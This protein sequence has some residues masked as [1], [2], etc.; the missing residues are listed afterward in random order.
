[1]KPRIAVICAP[2]PGN[3]GM[4]S[5]DL[6]AVDFLSRNGFR[7]DLFTSHTPPRRGR[8][9][10]LPY[11]V[12][13]GHKS[14]SGFGVLKLNRFSN[15]RQF[16]KYTDVLYWGD[17]TPNPMY[18]FED[19]QRLEKRHKIKATKEQSLEKWSRLYNLSG[20]KISSN[21]VAVG[22]NFQHD[23]TDPNH[24]YKKYLR[25]LESNFD[26]I[27]PR[28]T[29][30][31]EN[32]KAHFSVEGKSKILPG[33]DPAFLLKDKSLSHENSKSQTFCYRF[34]R[35]K[36]PE[37]HGFINDIERLTGC[38][39]VHLDSWDKLDKSTA[40]SVFYN[41]IINIQRSRF[42]VTDLYHLAIN[43]IRLNVPAFGIGNCVE[44]QVGSLGDFK[45]KVLF[46][47]LGLERYYIE[48]EK[49]NGY[50]LRKATTSIVDELRNY[51][52]NVSTIYNLKDRLVRE[53]DERLLSSLTRI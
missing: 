39:G 8:Q 30:S 4:Y 37:I 25:N 16:Q 33:L 42:V 36:L 52:T 19:F 45:K 10:L 12:E 24:L 17:F 38:K 31:V 43:A 11:R 48:V 41:Y 18:A 14:K 27:L 32:L 26:L 13:I 9:R 5:V 6:A 47:M 20:G 7:F 3:A 53:F 22:N 1:M 49:E 34:A 46:K 50:D 15:I 21:T 23:Y 2:N 40:D 35:S 51:E 44:S 28:D 29:F